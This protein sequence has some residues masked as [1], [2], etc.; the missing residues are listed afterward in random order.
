M[1]GLK[2]AKRDANTEFGK[3]VIDN[4]TSSLPNAYKS[5]KNRVFG[6]KK[7]KLTAAPVQNYYPTKLAPS[8][9]YYN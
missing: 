2:L 8:G 5:I 6:C 3:T 7:N 1:H 9:E 4:A